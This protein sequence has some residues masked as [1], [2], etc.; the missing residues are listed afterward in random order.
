MRLTSQNGAGDIVYGADSRPTEALT[1]FALGADLLLVEATLPRP[2]RTGMRGHLTPGEAGQHAREAGREAARAHAHLGRARPRLGAQG[3]RGD[4]RRPGRGGDRGRDLRR[5]AGSGPVTTRSACHTV[6]RRCSHP[7][8]CLWCSPAGPPPA[9]R[10]A[11]RVGGSSATPPAR[12]RSRGRIAG[13]LGYRPPLGDRPAPAGA[14]RGRPPAL[15]T[16]VDGVA[17]DAH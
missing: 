17:Q 12:R 13:G 10:L 4:L 16:R 14:Q 9:M 2:E 1:E 6:P 5:V 3:G 11:A 15:R 7:A 8:A